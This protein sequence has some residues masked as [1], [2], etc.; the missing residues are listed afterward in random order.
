MLT[1]GTERKNNSAAV[2]GTFICSCIHS[3][4][5]RA[6]WMNVNPPLCASRYLQ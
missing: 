5:I 4:I 1:N 2:S 6:G 3:F